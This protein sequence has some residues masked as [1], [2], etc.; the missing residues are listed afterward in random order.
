MNSNDGFSE[1]S[2]D[3]ASSI[4][5]SKFPN[6][7]RYFN[8]FERTNGLPEMKD[9]LPNLLIWIRLIVEPDDGEWID[10]SKFFKFNKEDSI[11]FSCWGRHSRWKNVFWPFAQNNLEFVKEKCLELAEAHGDPSVEDYVKNAMD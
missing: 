7:E 11:E 3:G 8:H 1:D 4:D 9:C 2:R 5:L 10:P 6:L